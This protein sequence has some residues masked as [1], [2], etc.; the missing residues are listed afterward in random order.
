MTRHRILLAIFSL[1]VITLLVLSCGGS[2]DSTPPTQAPP[3]PTDSDSD[4]IRDTFDNCP[5]IWN[6]SQSDVDGDGIGDSCDIDIDDDGVVNTSD[7]CPFVYNPDQEDLDSD[8]IGEICDD[9]DNDL[10]FN[11]DDN[12]PDQ[13]NPNQADNEGDGIGDICDPDDDNDTVPDFRDNCPTTYNPAQ[14]DL[15]LDGHGTACDPNEPSIILWVTNASLEP[16][17]CADGGRILYPVIVTLQNI[18]NA[19]AEIQTVTIQVFDK[20]QSVGYFTFED[21][22]TTVSL[23]GNDAS[24]YL[25]AQLQI[26]GCG[27]EATFTLHF[28]S[29]YVTTA[30]VSN[31]GFVKRADRDCGS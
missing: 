15:D 7:N 26:E 21:G 6:Q 11:P 3:A 25:P 2:D 8:G 27:G 5:Q 18:G 23:C 22:I 30:R 24:S 12:C 28:I 20:E 10:V 31:I 16:K 4:G 13:F 29:A 19:D 9:N 17:I 1:T 14:T